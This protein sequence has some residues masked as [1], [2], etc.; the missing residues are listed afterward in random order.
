MPLAT[1]TLSH[2]TSCCGT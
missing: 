1:N 2:Y